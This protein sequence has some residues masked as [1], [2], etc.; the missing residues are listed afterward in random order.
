MLEQK[1]EQISLSI[2]PEREESDGWLEKKKRALKKLALERKKGSEK[3]DRKQEAIKQKIER[4]SVSI[5][6]GDER[7]AKYHTVARWMVVMYV[8]CVEAYLQDLLTAA[9]EADSEIM[10][11]SKQEIRYADVIAGGTFN[12]LVEKMRRTWVDNWMAGPPSKWFERLD[13]TYAPKFEAGTRETMKLCWEMRHLVVHDAGRI[14]PKFLIS[15]PDSA[16][17]VDD[18]LTIIPK[19]ILA[20]GTAIGNFV[21]PIDHCLLRRYPSLN[22]N[23]KPRKT[24]WNPNA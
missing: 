3:L 20:F 12:A 8:T 9:I 21:R 6:T 4:V 1:L 11:D 5:A 2:K 17:K 15:H 14:T 18:Y 7:I 24:G 10:G 23:S 22:V 16:K 19:Q 13:K